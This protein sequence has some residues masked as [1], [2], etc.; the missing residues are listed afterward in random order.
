MIEVKPENLTSDDNVEIAF[1]IVCPF[2][3]NTKTIVGSQFIID[4][5]WP[6]P[7]QPCGSPP[8]PPFPDTW[9]VGRLQTGEYQVIAKSPF[10]V[11]ETLAFSVSQ[12]ELPFPTPPIPSLGFAGVILLATA[13]VWIANKAF[14][15]TPKGSTQLKG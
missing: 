4:A 3:V 5:D 8:V 12:G 9:S 15:P 6:V 10:G 11:Q 13:L 1:D 14:K 2:F 7:G